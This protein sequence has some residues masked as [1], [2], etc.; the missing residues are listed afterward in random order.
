MN[1]TEPT[2]HRPAAASARSRWRLR[3][4]LRWTLLIALAPLLGA[5]LAGFFILLTGAGIWL[6]MTMADVRNTQ[7]CAAQGRRN[8]GTIETPDR[9]RY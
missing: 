9:S 5:V 1:A 7:D 6:F 8:C 3:L 2:G 4:G